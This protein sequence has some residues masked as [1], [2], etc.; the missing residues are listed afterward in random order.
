MVSTF[1]VKYKLN[2]AND[3]KESL[4]YQKLM[5]ATANAKGFIDRSELPPVNGAEFH[6]VVLRFD[7]AQNAENWMSSDLRKQ[8][9]RQAALSHI[10]DKE[11]MLHIGNQFWFQ[12]GQ[13]R[14]IPG[15]KQ[16]IA[17]FLAVYP[18]TVFVPK[19][20]LLFFMTMGVTSVVMRGIM[21]SIVIS[22]L[23][24]YVAMPV[25]LRWL[26]SWMYRGKQ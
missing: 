7:T 12:S 4:W 23:M 20:V 15:W 18:L 19:I 3:P 24:V 1:I 17:S 21:V 22:T 8:I 11:E 25:I 26:G 16:V 6:T 10:S 2:N 13:K 9:L 5:E 14:K